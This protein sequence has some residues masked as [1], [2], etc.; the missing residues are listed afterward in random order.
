M[1]PSSKSLLSDSQSFL[2]FLE[3]WLV[4]LPS[5]SISNAV[6][7]PEKT[8]VLCVD[9]TRGFC[10]EG[11]LSSPRVN[12]IISPIVRLME[13]NWK[14]GVKHYL[15]PFDAHEP[16]A[17]EFK[18]YPPHCVRG[19]PEAETV[20]EIKSLPFFD[21]M[22]LMPKN[23]IDSRLNTPMNEWLTAHPDV[24]TFFV[25]GDCTDI[26][27]YQLAM[28]LQIEANAYQKNR[29]VI[30]PANCVDTYDRTVGTAQEQGGLPHSGDLLHAIF[31]YHMALN[32][33][34]VVRQIVDG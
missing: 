28:S 9:I 33:V 2:N 12:S 4:N 5:L 1:N 18:A 21:Q 15:I 24:D 20:P 3:E 19:T 6:I 32:G 26:C 10:T 25:V 13:L 30:V 11:P 22:L 14:A 17:E 7:N 31:L 34:E 27:V 16:D 29:R 23:S 8:A